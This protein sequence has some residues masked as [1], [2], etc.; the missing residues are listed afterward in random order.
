MS[1]ELRHFQR[2]SI[3]MGTLGGELHYQGEDE[4]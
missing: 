3:P 4:A 2:V 1:Q